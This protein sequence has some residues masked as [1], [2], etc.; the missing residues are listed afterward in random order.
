MDIP[1]AEGSI[2]SAMKYLDTQFSALDFN[3]NDNFDGSTGTSDPSA[4][5]ALSNKYSQSV[6][7]NTATHT[8][9]PAM[10]TFQATQSSK[11]S[12]SSTNISSVLNQNNKVQVFYY[13]ALRHGTFESVIFLYTY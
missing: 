5:A 13:L 8:E 12:H 10:N 1:S 6:T 3:S 4:V 2:T 11:S 9:L 7:G